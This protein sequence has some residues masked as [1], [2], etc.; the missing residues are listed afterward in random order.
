M[1][2][3]NF[4][5]SHQMDRTTS[6]DTKIDKSVDFSTLFPTVTSVAEAVATVADALKHK[7]SSSISIP[8]KDMRNDKSLRLYGVDSLVAI[9][10]RNW[11]A[12]KLDADVAVFDILGESTFKGNGM[13]AAAR[14]SYK[15]AWWVGN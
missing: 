11:F 9:E 5:H 13:L 14:S 6:T 10:L 8:K 2:Q 3:P 12:K 4:N 1:H 15:Q 7:F